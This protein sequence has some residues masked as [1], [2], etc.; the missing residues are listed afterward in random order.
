MLRAVLSQSLSM[1]VD[2]QPGVFDSFIESNAPR[3]F[4]VTIKTNWV[5]GPGKVSVVILS[6]SGWSSFDKEQQLT[7]IRPS[8]SPATEIETGKLPFSADHKNEVLTIRAQVI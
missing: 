8:Q 2:P 3:D 4:P 6:S 1:S 7:V 5:R